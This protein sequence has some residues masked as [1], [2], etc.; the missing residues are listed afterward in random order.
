MVKRW[1]LTSIFSKLR[2]TG[3]PNMKTVQCSLHKQFPIFNGGYSKC[4]QQSPQCV[5]TLEPWK[6]HV[7]AQTSI[8]G[9]NS[10]FTRRCET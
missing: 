5:E 2:T 6:S 3:Y 10:Y 7:H 8:L 9:S 1:I 4:V